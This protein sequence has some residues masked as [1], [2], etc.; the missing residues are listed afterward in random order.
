MKRD[1]I[2]IYILGT[3]HS[4]STLLDVILGSHSDVISTGE[5][6]AFPYWIQNNRNCSCGR[7]ILECP[8]WGGVLERLNREG[9]WNSGVVS[10]L[11]ELRELGVL[12][13]MRSAFGVG[14][15]L[16]LEQLKEYALK[17]SALFEAIAEQSGVR[18]IVDSSK[19]L[20]RL[21]KLFF[22]G[23]FR[24][25]IIH[26]VRDGRYAVDA[27]RRAAKRRA[28]RTGKK[29]PRRFSSALWIYSGWAITMLAQLGFLKRVDPSNYLRI[30]YEELAMYPHRTVKRL[31]D[32]LKIDF[33]PEVLNPSSP[34]YLF[35]QEHHVIG[36]SRLL[37]QVQTNP[38]TPI[39]YHNTWEKNISKLDQL[40]F[41]LL[42]GHFINARLGIP[43]K[44]D[45]NEN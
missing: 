27:T 19:R 6:W 22:S 16:N 44:R 21:Q 34:R 29:Q 45:R 13:K 5:L 1:F 31:C 14:V 3:A 33:Q 38:E 41:T 24:I 15:S 11:K 2:V 40:V 39:I 18:Y 28:S 26:L 42:G 32:F 9:E 35:K 20:D 7:P 43:R 25:K 37:R 36:G 10:K 12:W 30:S 23:C 17:E 8:H 4:G